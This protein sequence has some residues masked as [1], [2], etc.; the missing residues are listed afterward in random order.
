MKKFFCFLFLSLFFCNLS[1]SDCLEDIDDK[2]QWIGNKAA[3]EFTWKNTND[4]SIIISMHGLKS[5]NGSFM[6]K[7]DDDIYLKP[8]GIKSAQLYT[9]DLNTDVA[10][11]ATWSCRYGT[12]VV[13]Q[14]KVDQNK[15]KFR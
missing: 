13:E 7:S 15:D 4:K 10:G 1:Y 9:Y 3:I 2:M 14:P 12:K 8:F 6:I 5:I 11:K